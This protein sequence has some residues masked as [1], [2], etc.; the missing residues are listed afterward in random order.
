M[1]VHACLQVCVCVCVYIY[2]CLRGNVYFFL[3]NPSTVNMHI[4]AG[5]FSLST[6]W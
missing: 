5:N 2:A 6:H 1:C 4:L 3:P